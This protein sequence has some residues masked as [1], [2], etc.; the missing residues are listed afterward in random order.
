MYIG[1]SLELL[2]AS[3]APLDKGTAGGRRDRAKDALLC[4]LILC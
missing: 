3:L 1:D 4:Y 2:E